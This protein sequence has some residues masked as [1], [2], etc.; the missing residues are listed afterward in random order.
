MKACLARI[1]YKNWMSKHVTKNMKRM[2]AALSSGEIFEHFE[3]R[4]SMN[5]DHSDEMFERIDFLIIVMLWVCFA[6]LVFL[7]SGEPNWIEVASILWNPLKIVTRL[8]DLIVSA[9]LFEHQ[10]VMNKAI[11]NYP[12][13]IKA[14]QRMRDVAEE[15]GDQ[16]I[17][18]R[19]YLQLGQTL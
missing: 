8:P 1:I 12:G 3:L 14:F 13:A 6:E 19:A 4:I 2:Q 17:E 16:Q 10:G 9:A 7:R 18:M 5:N 11:K 15:L